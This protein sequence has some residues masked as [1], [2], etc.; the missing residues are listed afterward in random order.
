MVLGTALV[1]YVYTRTRGE[2]WHGICVREHL[3]I[4]EVFLSASLEIGLMTLPQFIDAS[5]F[6]C[7]F[8]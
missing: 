2:I 3:L 8:R 5:L 7:Y 1:T 4:G 6:S